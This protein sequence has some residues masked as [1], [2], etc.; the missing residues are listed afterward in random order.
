MAVTRK[1]KTKKNDESQRSKKK[2]K[3]FSRRE[4]ILLSA[5]GI[6]T[7]GGLLFCFLMIMLMT[8]I[9]Y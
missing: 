7:F 6:V 4:I 8:S 2:K 1:L 9:S 5:T 3:E